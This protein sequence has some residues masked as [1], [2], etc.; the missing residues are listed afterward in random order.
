MFLYHQYLLRLSYNILLNDSASIEPALDQGG[1][2][3]RY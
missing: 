3:M 1:L 2:E